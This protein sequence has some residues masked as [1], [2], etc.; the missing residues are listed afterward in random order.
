MNR[1]IS[2]A[3]LQDLLSV[4]QRRFAG[5]GAFHSLAR[6][7]RDSGSGLRS[8]HIR[9]H[10]AALSILVRCNSGCFAHLPGAVLIICV[11]LSARKPEPPALDATVLD[12][13]RNRL[14]WLDGQIHLLQTVVWWY[15]APLCLGSLL[16]TWG[17]TRGEW[18]VFGLQALFALAVAAGIVALNRWAVRT[19]LVP[20]REDL[21]GLSAA[22]E[23]G[24]QKE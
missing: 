4:V 7:S 20:V 22:L 16:L 19:S 24:E 1:S 2:S 18:L 12:F 9:R 11:L 17:I 8:W 15:V 13:S 10:V 5:D 23:S 21:C 3:E 6:R 14:A